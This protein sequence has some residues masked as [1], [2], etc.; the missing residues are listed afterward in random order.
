MGAEGNDAADGFTAIERALRTVGDFETVAG[1]HAGAAEE[2]LVIGVGV[3]E[4]D[5]VDEKER[6]IGVGA[7]HK[8]RPERAV[9]TRSKQGRTARVAEGVFERCLLATRELGRGECFNEDTQRGR[10]GGRAR[11]ERDYGGE[12]RGRGLGAKTPVRAGAQRAQQ[13]T[14]TRRT[15]R[16]HGQE[17]TRGPRRARN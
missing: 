9:G 17:P 2:H 16:E 1:T 5:A 15:G 8:E 3:I 14:S 4:A 6:L 11:T 13:K 12:L 7:A 10:S